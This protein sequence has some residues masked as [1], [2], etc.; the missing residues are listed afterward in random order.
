MNEIKAAAHERLPRQSLDHK[1]QILGHEIFT[2]RF[3]PSWLLKMEG[4]NA[5][6][7]QRMDTK[8]V[9]QPILSL[10]RPCAGLWTYY[11]LTAVLSGPAIFVTLPYLYF[12]YYTLRYRFDEEGIH[13][14]VGILFRREVNLTYARIQDIH[15]TSNLVER[16]LGLARIQIQTA[17]GSAKAEMTV[18]GVREF[19]AL[20][21]F[22]YSRMRGVKG[23]PAASGGAA[24]HATPARVGG[25][26]LGEVAATLEET[27]RELRAIRIALEG[28]ERGEVDG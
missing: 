18:E 11:I 22:L 24:P 4:R 5:L 10:E 27:V 2:E 16:W 21:D 23:I 14:R 6:I 26:D 3:G 1:R 19:G 8:P 17:S 7:A 25:G 12:R 9:P 15:L 28:R 20:R 13:M